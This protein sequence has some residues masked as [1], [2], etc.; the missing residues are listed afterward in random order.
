MTRGFDCS[1]LE[2]D[3]IGNTLGVDVRPFPFQ[4]PV[5]GEHVED[6]RRLVAVAQESLSAKGLIDGAAFAPEAERLI[7]LFGRGRVAIVML[8]DAGGRTYRVRAVIDRAAGVVAAQR[9]ELVRFT[10]VRPE[11]VVRSVVGLLPPLRP[12]PG[13]SVTLTTTPPD[14]P[15]R[16]RQDEDFSALSYL[17]TARPARDIPGG[18][19]DAA[20]QIARRPRQG[21]GYFTVTARDRAGHDGQPATLTWL[22]TDAGR[23]AIIPSTSA[24]GRL[25]VTYTPADLARLEHTLSRLVSEVL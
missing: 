15:N 14:I 13:S 5:H 21:N 20:E 2:L 22:D 7:T 18:Q 25:H 1:L 4:F 23:Y 3:L 17:E 6:R 8:G 10:P 12:G 16:R 11:S 24:D 9:G 19:W